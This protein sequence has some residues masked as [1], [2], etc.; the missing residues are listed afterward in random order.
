MG[1]QVSGQVGGQPDRQAGRWVSRKV[2]RSVHEYRLGGWVGVHANDRSEVSQK[3][4]SRPPCSAMAMVPPC[5][6]ANSIA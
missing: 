1:R 3:C 6:K 2:G 5:I 4:I